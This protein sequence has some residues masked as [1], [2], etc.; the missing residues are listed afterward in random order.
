MA[1]SNPR[2]VMVEAVAGQ[3]LE[4]G[5]IYHLVPD[6][7]D[8][9]DRE[10]G[11]TAQAFDSSPAQADSLVGLYGV[12]DCTGREPTAAG[13]IKGPKEGEAASFVISGEARVQ[14]H[15]HTV[16]ITT[17][18]LLYIGDSNIG[19]GESSGRLVTSVARSAASDQIS[20]LDIGTSAGKAQ[21]Y[22]GFVRAKA[23]ITAG[24]TAGAN[25]YR[26][27]HVIVYNNPGVAG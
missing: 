20:G 24:V 19:G 9:D 14:V 4:Y 27:I 2:R 6:V 18:C 25:V 10:A 22:F 26:T 15:A 21:S 5:M 17:G 23:L 11:F 8:G 13:M 1:L 12:L 7:T 3:D 16:D